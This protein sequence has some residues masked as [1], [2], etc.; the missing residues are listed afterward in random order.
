MNTFARIV[1]GAMLMLLA[2]A[3]TLATNSVVSELA[4]SITPNDGGYAY[5]YTVTLA[6]SGESLI[7]ILLDAERDGVPGSPS[8]WHSIVYSY[9]ATY[10]W[11]AHGGHRIC[12]NGWSPCRTDADILPGMTGGGFSVT[13]Q[14]PPRIQT[15]YLRSFRKDPWPQPEEPDPTIPK[16]VFN[17][18]CNSLKM[19]TLSPKD[20][21]SLIGLTQLLATD[22]GT[23]F[24][25]LHWITSKP[26][27]DGLKRINEQLQDALQ[28]NNRAAAKRLSESLADEAQ[29]LFPKDINQSAKDLVVLDAMYINARL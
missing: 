26:A 7:Q 29:R 17:Q 25:T 6:D 18:F 8:H 9:R 22:I 23:A 20:P 28:K 5:A 11:R 4:V 16:C 24:N 19:Q 13:S 10:A 3:Y 27:Y 15:I 21:G 1:L 2:T 14:F 12:P